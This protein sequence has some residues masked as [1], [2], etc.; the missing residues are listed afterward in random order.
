MLI[1]FSRGVFYCTPTA[2]G[3]IMQSKNL[4]YCYSFRLAY[5]IKSQGIDYEFKGKNKNNGL[6]YFAFLKSDLL[7]NII[8]QWNRLKLK[9]D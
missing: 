4:F 2:L 6:T 1:F 7:D 8:Q 3:G 5:F 9:E